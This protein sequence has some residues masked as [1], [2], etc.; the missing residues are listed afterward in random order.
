M[1]HSEY[2]FDTKHDRYPV[3]VH[4]FLVD[5][6]G[7]ILL[8]RRAGSGYADGLLGL[9]SGH[10]DLGET[11]TESI[12]REVREELGVELE[13]AGLRPVGTMFRRS[14]EPRVDIFFSVMSWSG[15]PR[16][17]EPHKCTELVWSDPAGLP[18]DALDFIG[19]AW[20]DAQSGR[21]FREFGFTAVAA[22]A[23]HT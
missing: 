17:R 2:V 6:A 9:P 14:Q 15:E 16:I 23:G 10:V 19:Q 12:V 4:V 20:Q 13:L 22:Q 8:M 1:S 7:R 3:A 21:V 5:C 11:P 18:E